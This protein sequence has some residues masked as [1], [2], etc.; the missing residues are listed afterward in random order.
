MSFTRKI[1]SANTDHELIVQFKSTGNLD[2]LG[3]L[4][5]RY[6]DLVYGVSLK[7]LKQPEDAKDSVMNIF[8]EL[9]IKL[10]KHQVENFKSWLYQ[11]TKNHCL[12][13]LRSRKIIH[14]NIELTTVQFQENVHLDDVHQKEEN[15]QHMEYCL[16][17]LEP[18][19]RQVIEMFYKLD[20]CYREISDETG[21]E[22]GKVRSYL[23]NGRRNLRICMEKQLNKQVK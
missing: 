23:Q 6:M 16:M 19:Q 1:S 13:R 10:R 17:R 14:V 8:E 21:L 22:P 4:Y 11:V 18:Q 15:F 7:Y 12:G 5:Q 2:I 20:K 9:V 3:E